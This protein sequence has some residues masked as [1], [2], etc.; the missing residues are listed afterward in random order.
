MD[1]FVS[2]VVCKD[3][4]FLTGDH[5]WGELLDAWLYGSKAA[6]SDAEELGGTVMCVINKKLYQLK[7]CGP[8][9]VM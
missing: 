5:T 9:W 6:F 8:K 2:L 3:G 7:E 4:K 1:D